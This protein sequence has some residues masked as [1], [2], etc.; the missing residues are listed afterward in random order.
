MTDILP[1]HLIFA[2]L[3]EAMRY[4]E[5]KG[6]FPTS[7]ARNASGEFRVLFTKSQKENRGN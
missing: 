3:V 1:T 4:F 6:K 2:E 5:K 7:A